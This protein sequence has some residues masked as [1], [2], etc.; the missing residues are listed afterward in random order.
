MIGTTLHPNTNEKIVVLEDVGE[1]GYRVHRCLMHM[2]NA[3]L[4]ANTKA[5][6]FGDFTGSD[7][8]LQSS[9][10]HFIEQYLSSIPVF[11]TTGIGH[12]AT[13]R[14][15]P[16]GVAGVIQ[17]NQISITSPFKVV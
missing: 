5:V 16:F 12:G 13:S 15:L 8:H 9:I 11:K 1:Q 10:E 6:I 4:F 7:K 14:P 17:N 2:Q 3:G